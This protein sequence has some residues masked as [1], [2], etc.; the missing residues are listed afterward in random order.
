MGLCPGSGKV[1]FEASGEVFAYQGV[2]VQGVLSMGLR[3]GQQVEVPQ[4]FQGVIV[5]GVVRGWQIIGQALY[6]GWLAQGI[7]GAGGS[8]AV[9]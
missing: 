7:D 1:V 3:R 9:E 2:A 8:G 4:V 6:D 5:F